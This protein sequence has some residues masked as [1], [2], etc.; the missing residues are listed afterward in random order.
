MPEDMTVA[1]LEGV[2]IARYPRL[3]KL[4]PRCRVALDQQFAQPEDPVTPK[5]KVALIPPVSGG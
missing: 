1:E 3:G 4:W 2:L 5:R